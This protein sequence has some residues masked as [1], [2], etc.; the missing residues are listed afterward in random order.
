VTIKP[1]VYKVEPEQQLTAELVPREAAF[2]VLAINPPLGA[3]KLPS[4]LVGIQQPAATAVVR[5]DAH[6]T[7]PN[8]EPT[9]RSGSRGGG[10]SSSGRAGDPREIQARRRERMRGRLPCDRRCFWW[11]A[12]LGIRRAYAASSI[13]L[14]QRAAFRSDCGSDVNLA[15]IASITASAAALAFA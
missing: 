15:S 1:G 2:F 4:E 6:A 14:R 12:T 5:R 7:L 3:A 9:A 13:D 8:G 11:Q 10:G